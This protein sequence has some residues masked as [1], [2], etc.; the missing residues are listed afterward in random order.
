MT[1]CKTK[2]HNIFKPI[3]ARITSSKYNLNFITD[4]AYI[5]EDG[6]FTFGHSILLTSKTSPQKTSKPVAYDI[7]NDFFKNASDGDIIQITPDGIISVLWEKRLN[8]HDF[9][10]F[11]T[12]QCNANCIMCPQPPKKDE[13][14]LM[15][16]NKKILKYLSK[17]PIKMIGITGG[18]PT[19][20][21]NDLLELTSLA[22][23]YYPS[24]DINLLTNGKKLSDFNYAKELALSNPNITFCVS[25]PSDNMDDSNEIMRTHIY[26]D[27]L[28]AIQNLAI[29]R[30][31]IEL[32]IV[33][34]KQNYKR[35]LEIAQFIY[36]NFPFIY[37]IAFMGMEVTGYAFDNIDD[38]NI[39]PSLYNDRLLS[40][41]QFLHQRD[42]HVSVYNI[43]FCLVDKRMWKFVKNSISKW[44]QSYNLECNL[45]SKK[46]I[47]SGIFTTTKINNFKLQP[48]LE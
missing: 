43:P 44:K 34:L 8:P 41:V 28:K 6:Q 30:Q 26:V 48:I 25:F 3:V 40:A 42:M 18:E 46:S 29:L 47:C 20:K 36:R 31:K 23:K 21:K 35:L 32:R 19:L 12:H 15:D 11:I 22:Y 38:I 37:H 10:L 5:R 17:E 39:E 14:S 4:T 1:T 27:V 13:Y 24:A 7:D 16:T 9:T 45:C 33:I 2:I